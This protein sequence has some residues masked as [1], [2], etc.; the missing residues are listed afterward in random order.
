[1]ARIGSLIGKTFGGLFDSNEK[2]LKKLGSIVD[3]V[4]S[5][6]SDFHSLSDDALQANSETLRQELAHGA[7][8]DDILPQAFAAVR[9]TSLRTV[10]LRHFDVQLAGGI[11]LHRGH[12]AEMKTGEGKTLAAT[13]PLYLNALEAEGCHLVT[14]NDYLAKR[15]CLWMGP[16]Y[17]GLGL[18]VACITGRQDDRTQRPAYLYDPAYESPD[19]RWSQLRPVS[20]YE[21]YQA[22]ITYGTNN[23]FGFD[24]LRDN[25]VNDLSQCV[26]RRLHYAIVDEVDNILIDEARTPLIIS[27]ASEEAANRYVIFD[28]VVSRLVRDTDYEVDERTRSVNLTDDIG[29]PKVESMLQQQGL[30]KGPSL[31]DHSNFVLTHYLQSALRA[32]AL[33]RRDHDY[34]VK[35]G[36]VIIVDE[37]T[38]RLMPGRRYS[39]GLHQAIEA[40]EH[41]QIQRESV[42]HATITFQNY[43][44]MYAK[45]AG[46]TGTAATEAEEFSS[47]YS[48]E[49][50]EVPTNMPMIRRDLSDRIYRDETVKFT[51]VANEV[52]QAHATGRPVLVGTTSI[53]TSEVLSDLFTRRGLRAQVLNAK[54]HE[55]EA[56]IIAEAGRLEAITVATN[57]AGRG[58][59]IILGGNPANRSPEEW[60]KEHDAVVEAGGLYVLGTEHHEAR[61]IDNQ[62]RGRS[63]RQGDPGAT[64]FFVSLDDEI[65]HRF[66]GDRVKS[67]MEWAGMDDQTP[68]E[69]PVVTRAI[70]NAQVQT[71]GYHF[72]TRKHLVEYDDVLNK[73]R[74]VIYDERRKVLSGTDL[75]E[76]ILSMLD[77]EI[78]IA[79][80]AHLDSSLE[81]MDGD[82]LLEELNA[83]FPVSPEFAK[84]AFHQLPSAHMR[85]T[86]VDKVT[87]YA[88]QVYEERESELGAQAM[89][90]AERFVMLRVID[91]LWMEHLT[92]MEHMRVGIGL[93]AAGQQKPLDVYKKEGHALFEGL[94]AAIKH[95]VAAG[96]FRV[97]IKTQQPSPAAKPP[98]EKRGVAPSGK[99]VGRNDPCPCGSGRK[100]KHCC[101]K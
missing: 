25:M 77:E 48:L 42:T 3:R 12:I 76:N 19:D 87:Q 85:D 16:V 89:R 7:S 39:E 41:V 46:M 17:R 99:R 56:S 63:G 73:H 4:N 32:H 52:A 36:Q 54:N 50:L 65:M 29:I 47:I 28:R 101:G 14:V 61:R 58:V 37:F 8:L 21:A 35:N 9:E 33:F 53:E 1:M 94:L 96:M 26:Q 82:A 10:G 90:F 22:D 2:Q 13:L 24:Y 38:G 64:C 98:S 100:Y 70:A 43:F 78:E 5:L 66:G 88:H 83:F 72:D 49:V 31:F 27:A 45:L 71:E 91:R 62:L 69:H 23:E 79:V 59:D 75:R 51:A 15:D 11:T 20:R 80:D 40:R 30:L 68:I 95:D 81:E 6:E 18:S 92:V 84:D 74:Q 57:M 55:R 44:R 86:V 34:V 93:R 60:Q 97:S 67:V